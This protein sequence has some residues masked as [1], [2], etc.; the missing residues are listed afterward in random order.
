M[1]SSDKVSLYLRK[2]DCGLVA[3]FAFH[4]SRDTSDHDD[5]V[6]VRNILC[7]GL[8][9]N[10]LTLADVSLECGEMVCA[11][12]VLDHDVVCLTFYD[13]EALVLDSA[14]SSTAA[15]SCSFLDYLTVDLQE[16][17]VVSVDV[18][19]HFTCESGS[20]LSCHTDR[21]VFCVHS[22]SEA[23][24]SE[25]GEVQRVVVSCHIRVA[26]EVLV[27]VELYVY[28]LSVVEFVEVSDCHY[29][30]V[31]RTYRVVVYFCSRNGLS[32]AVQK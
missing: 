14:S 1:H 12:L 30:V 9:F 15:A 27:V 22:V 2:L 19:F 7:N 28:A 4:L 17:A 16:I 29:V 31:E 6:S 24:C 10:R 3:A 23:V 5:H 20:V 26:F 21:K 25:C 32:D 11:S 18:V 8:I 13:I